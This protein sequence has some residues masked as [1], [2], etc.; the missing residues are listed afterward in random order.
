MSV[1][2]RLKL[3]Q[4]VNIAYLGGSI[5]EAE[6]GSDKYKYSWAYQVEQY[7]RNN[8]SNQLSFHN[9][10]VSGTGSGLGI[11]RLSRDIL[12]FKPDLI[13]IEYAINDLTE[14]DKARQRY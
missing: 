1:L 5:T 12:P 2:E 9:A 13:F 14:I 6:Y 8:Y 3:K 4:A 10:G 7:F 11:F